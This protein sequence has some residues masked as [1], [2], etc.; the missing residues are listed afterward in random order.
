[1]P[2]TLN[3]FTASRLVSSPAVHHLPY[4]LITDHLMSSSHIKSPLASVA[5]LLFA[6]LLAFGCSSPPS[7]SSVT[8]RYVLDQEASKKAL[9][10]WEAHMARGMGESP[11]GIG[12]AS[13]Y[14]A[15]MEE[16]YLTVRADG[17]FELPDG[18]SGT[19]RLNKSTLT[20][21]DTTVADAKIA[22][23]YE[24]K[25]LTSML[26]DML[27]GDVEKAFTGMINSGKTSFTTE[28]REAYQEQYGGFECAVDAEKVSCTM[29]ETALFVEMTEVVAALHEKAAEEGMNSRTAIAA[30]MP[31]PDPEAMRK[32]ARQPMM[33]F[34][35]E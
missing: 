33:V 24:T 34:V 22:D 7:E 23:F 25:G 27:A 20:L 18:V 21:V 8:G 11:E 6:I 4:T 29:R 32:A 35:K 10:T 1:M 5:V 9:E 30:Q 17:T 16:E 14:A 19:W 31:N 3:G 2:S 12:S 15:T 26:Q 28:E 13:G